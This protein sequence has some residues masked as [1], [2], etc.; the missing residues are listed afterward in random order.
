MKPRDFFLLVAE[1]RRLQKEYFKTRDKAVL[2]EAKAKEN[3]LD[4]EIAR[5]EAITKEEIERLLAERKQ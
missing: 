1:T 2:A 4:A 3:M 5:V